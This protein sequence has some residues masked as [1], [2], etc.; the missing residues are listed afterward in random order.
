MTVNL[1]Q[2]PDGN[3]RPRRSKPANSSPSFEPNFSGPVDN[4]VR[5]IL[6]QSRELLTAKNITIESDL[7]SFDATFDPKLVESALKSLL[8]NAALSLPDGGQISVTLIDGKYQWELEVADGTEV[9]SFEQLMSREQRTSD[10]TMASQP[11]TILPFPSTEQLRNALRMAMV[12]GGH[13]QTWDCPQGGTAHV[14][15]V[16]RRKHSSA[17]KDASSGKDQSDGQVA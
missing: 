17:T 1:Y 4:F 12:H 7:E 9:Q 5:Q 3:L 2:Q 13:I 6:N 11:P 14:L 16:P 10:E 8:E 15:V